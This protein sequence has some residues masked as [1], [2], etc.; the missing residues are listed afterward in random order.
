M[1]VC[2]AP[3]ASSG[4]RKWDDRF[5]GQVIALKERIDN[6]RCNIPPDRETGKNR[7]VPEEFFRCCRLCNAPTRSSA[8]AALE[9]PH[10]I[11]ENA[12]P[13]HCNSKIFFPLCLDIIYTYI[14]NLVYQ[15]A[16]T[17]DVQY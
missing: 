1:F 8:P 7:V 14:Y 4:G 6:C 15:A 13:I 16:V 12:L 10:R 9:H 17:R 2:L 5:A 3:T 11:T